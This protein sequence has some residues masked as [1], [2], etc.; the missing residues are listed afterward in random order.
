MNKLISLKTALVMTFLMLHMVS[1]SLFAEAQNVSGRR[2]SAGPIGDSAA[3][4]ANCQTIFDRFKNKTTI[5]MPARTISRSN[6]PREELSLSLQIVKTDASEAQQT[7]EIQLVFVSKSERYKYHEQADVT[8]IV[9][10][11]KVD[12]GTAYTL[13]GVPGTT[14]VQ[15]KMQLTL[16]AE[17]FQQI[18]RGSDVEMQMGATE[19]TLGKS[20]IEAMR[21]FAECAGLSRPKN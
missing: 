4:N 6:T 19:I 21:G 11:K 5:T 15:E 17:K 20:D 18:A 9:D 16:S 2:Q 13:G 3:S 14:Q 1:A 12:A 8:F 7:K 10:G